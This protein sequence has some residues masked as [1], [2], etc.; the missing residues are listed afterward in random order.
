MSVPNI[1]SAFLSWGMQLPKSTSKLLGQAYEMLESEL[2]ETSILPKGNVN[3]L[4]LL[5]WATLHWV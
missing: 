4:S 2:W 3:K 5:A 1:N